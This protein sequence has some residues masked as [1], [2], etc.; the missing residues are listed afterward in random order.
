MPRLDTR[1]AIV[2]GGGSGFGAGIAT[3]FTREGPG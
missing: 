3:A 1:I 2:T